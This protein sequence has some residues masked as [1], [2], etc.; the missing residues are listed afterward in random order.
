M[1]LITVDS[2]KKSNIKVCASD[3][4]LQQWPDEAMV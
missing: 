3:M 2:F 4:F 1:L